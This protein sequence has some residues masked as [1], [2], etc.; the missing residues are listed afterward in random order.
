MVFKCARI[1]HYV[2]DAYPNFIVSGA[3]L[4]YVHN[5]R[6]LG[7]GHI[8]DDKLQDDTDVRREIRKMFIRCNILLRRFGK[9]S[10]QVKVRLFKSFC[11]CLYG[12]ALWSHYTESVINSFK[13]C[14]HKCIKLFFGFRKYDSVTQ[15]LFTLGLPS[16]NTW[17]ISA[18]Q[19]FINS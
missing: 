1:S 8:L 10:V 3:T 5:F 9:C 15:I 14:Y 7:L 2:S 11:L 4:K 17:I 16:F 18:C 12:A 19:S 6:C 13:A